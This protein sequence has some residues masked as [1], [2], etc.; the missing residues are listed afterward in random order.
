MDARQRNYKRTYYVEGNTARKL[1]VLPNYERQLE[2]LEQPKVE[3][4]TVRAPRLNNGIDLLSA[5][6]LFTTM[7][8]ALYLCY[9]YLKVQGNNVQLKRD[10]VNLEAEYTSLAAANDVLSESMEKS[11]QLNW[12]DVYKTAI[13]EFGM[14]YPNNNEVVT[15]EKE[16]RGYVIMHSDI[17]E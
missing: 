8:I 2:V 14:V 16:E 3:K 15:Y 1:E 10:I 17:P 9:D 6:L 7:A 13:A 4:R 5:I 11:T 12:E